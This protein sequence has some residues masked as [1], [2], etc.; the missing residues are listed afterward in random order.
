M[1]NIV[2]AMTDQNRNPNVSLGADPTDNLMQFTMS[3]GGYEKLAQK[4]NPL[5]GGA[6]A[7]VT[8]QAIQQGATVANNAINMG[9][10]IYS[11]QNARKYKLNMLDTLYNTEQSLLG[12]DDPNRHKEVY[13]KTIEDLQTK[14]S[15]SGLMKKD[16]L[17]YFHVFLAGRKNEYT[18]QNF[19]L[20]QKK[21]GDDTQEEYNKTSTVLDSVVSNFDEQHLL[22]EN[23]A[24]N[25]KSTM[26]QNNVFSEEQADR[27][28]TKSQIKMI[29][30]AANS[31]ANP[32]MVEQ[33]AINIYE[34]KPN[35]DFRYFPSIQGNDRQSLGAQL[36]SIAGRNREGSYIL[37]LAQSQ[38]LENPVVLKDP[39]LD[40][41]QKARLISKNNILIEKLKEDG[42]NK[43]LKST[44]YMD[45][46]WQKNGEE[47]E[48]ILQNPKF[49]SMAIEF[50][51]NPIMLKE[52]VRSV[53][54]Q[55]RDK[56]ETDPM[57]T[58]LLDP[59]YSKLPR[60]NLINLQKM[61]WL[62]TNQ[63]QVLSQAEQK[64]YG[65]IF[66]N[67]MTPEEKMR[68]ANFNNDVTAGFLANIG[69]KDRT[70]QRQFVS[71]YQWDILN[72]VKTIAPEDKLALDIMA[73]NKNDVDS[74]IYAQRLFNISSNRFKTGGYSVDSSSII[75]P[76]MIPSGGYK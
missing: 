66:N 3:G 71:K 34:K 33:Y 55:Q 22:I 19:E 76:L 25:I 70:Q 6:E 64:N 50:G 37:K 5:S 14:L 48:T 16:N 72:N 43:F 69:L 1:F 26:M 47:I 58:M 7:L 11:D 63:V 61:F 24:K 57:G 28:S 73:R 68:V 9:L 36:K 32:A 67:A 46:I 38:P 74:N 56:F 59:R 20:I 35:G 65:D 27:Q 41:F 17:D 13:T 4:L 21:I 18:K 40:N 39:F 44:L 2:K 31:K 23:T 75:K 8:T 53:H 30:D 52:K 62:S 29:L 15:E 49:D 42:L 45:G 12:I 51:V 60:D 54:R 10:N